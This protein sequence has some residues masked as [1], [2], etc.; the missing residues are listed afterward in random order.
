MNLLELA[1]FVVELNG[2][3]VF[4]ITLDIAALVSSI[5]K[6]LNAIAFIRLAKAAGKFVSLVCSVCCKTEGK[7]A[8]E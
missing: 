6:L 2:S 4:N 1:D 3:I 8:K 7:R 5:A